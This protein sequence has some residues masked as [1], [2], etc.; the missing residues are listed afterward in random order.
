MVTSVDGLIS[1]MDTSSIITQLMQLERQPVTRLEQKKTAATA[2]SAAY[3][4]LNT[5]FVALQAAGDKLTQASFWQGRKA[6]SDSTSVTASASTAALTGSFTFDVEQVA[7]AQSYVSAATFSSTSASAT[8]SSSITIT[9]GAGTPVVVDVGDGS[10]ATVVARINASSAGIKAAATQV[11]AGV[12]R[13][14]LTS[15]T[16]GALS[17]F[18]IADGGNAT[19]LGALN[20]LVA[21][22]NAEIAVGEVGAPGRYTVSSASNTVADILPGVTLTVKGEATGVTVNVTADVDTVS[23]QVDGM[24]QA[25]NN[26]LAEIKKL[27]AYDTKTSKGGPLVGDSTLR[28]L[29]QEV[30]RIAGSAVGGSSS[31]AAAGVELNRDGTL[32]FTKATF[33]DAF[34]ADPLATARLFRPGGTTTHPNPVYEDLGGLVTFLSADDR[35]IPGSYDVKITAAANQAMVRVTGVVANGDE[36]SIT[37]PGKSAVVITADA[38]DG[39][40]DLAAKI[41]TASATSSLGIVARVEGGE[42]KVRTV[43]YGATPTLS[44]AATSAGLVADPVVA[45]TN[46]AGTINGVAATGTGQLLAAPATDPTLRGL[47]L[48]VTATDADVATAAGQAGAAQNLFGAFSYQPGLAQRLDSLSGDAVR[49]GTGRL[50]TAIAG[51]NELVENLTEQID[52]WDER[53]ELREATLRRQYANLETA[54]GKLRDQSNWLA[55]QIGGLAANSGS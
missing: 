17:D 42:L 47:S 14:Q 31:T 10:L 43:A 13:L 24:V 22:K 50:T 39:L 44:I 55:G 6:T 52:A 53:L 9:K 28:A 7:A 12:F 29:Q 49:S 20:E 26:V 34:N 18:T 25:A 19:P 2:E 1:G 32:K 3:Q 27:T 11:S 4:G 54:L 45:G 16:T 21:G 51:E 41:N 5:K 48:L 37:V 8:S 30:L 40:A 35:T 46:V 33:A 15:T 23:A 38:D 36:L